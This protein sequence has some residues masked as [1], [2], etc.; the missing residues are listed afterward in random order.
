MLSED[1]PKVMK[2]EY[3]FHHASHYYAPK[4]GQGEILAEYIDK[5]GACYVIND[6]GK[7]LHK[8]SVDQNKYDEI[9]F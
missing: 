9:D 3:R 4:R 2:D 5:D 8:G 7:I 6:K 1:A